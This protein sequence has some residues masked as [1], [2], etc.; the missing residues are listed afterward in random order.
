MQSHEQGFTL[1]ELIMII[2]L[3]GIL[4][5]VA[6]P[7]F[8]DRSDFDQR[9]YYEELISASRYAQKAALATGCRVGVTAVGSNYSLRYTGLPA[10]SGCNDAPVYHPGGNNYQGTAPT[11]IGASLSGPL[12]FGSLGQVVDAT[13][14]V[15]VTVTGTGASL[16]FTVTPQGFID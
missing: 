3:L 4:S 11:G 6:M 7:R 12:V 2:V 16:S 15:T 14:D 1:V 10:T 13:A 5:A 9:F 8:F